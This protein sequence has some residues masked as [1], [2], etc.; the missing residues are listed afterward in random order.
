MIKEEIYWTL[1]NKEK[2][3]KCKEQSSKCKEQSSKCKEQI[4]KIFVENE[5][6]PTLIFELWTLNFNKKE[7]LKCMQP[8]VI[9]HIKPTV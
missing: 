3:S 6:P 9:T 8:M 5:N 2:S 1:R 4:M 7:V